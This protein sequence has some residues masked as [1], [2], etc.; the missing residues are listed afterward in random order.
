MSAIQAWGDDGISSVFPIARLA[1]IGY[2]SFRMQ[3]AG[4]LLASSQS[5]AVSRG[6]VDIAPRGKTSV[7][8]LT[9]VSS[10]D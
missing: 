5:G 4:K 8:K 1:Y 10:A 3:P 6:A 7:I 9:S 2:G